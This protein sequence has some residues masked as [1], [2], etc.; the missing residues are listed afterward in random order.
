MFAESF[1]KTP[2]MK[3]YLKSAE[4]CEEIEG[5]Y[6]GTSTYKRTIVDAHCVLSLGAKL[7]NNKRRISF[8][9]MG[10]YEVVDVNMGG[11]Q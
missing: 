7:N 9:Y 8:V 6:Q 1:A 3:S 4:T 10:E 11:R 5:R 2:V